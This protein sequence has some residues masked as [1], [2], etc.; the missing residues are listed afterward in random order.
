MGLSAARLRE[1]LLCGF[2]FLSLGLARAGELSVTLLG[3]ATP[4]ASGAEIKIWLNVLNPSATAAAW[5]FPDG[6]NAKLRSGGRELPV[7]LQLAAAAAPDAIAPQG[8]ARAQYTLLLPAG[9]EGDALL[10]AEGLPGRAA[11][12][13]IQAAPAAATAPATS[14]APML[15]AEKAPNWRTQ[16]FDPVNYFKRHLF[17]HEPFYFV[18]GPDSPN[19]KFQ[20][21]FKYQLVDDRSGLAE[22]AGWA[23]NL[24]FGFTQTSL[25]DWNKASAPFEDSSYKPELMFQFQR[26]AQAGDSDWFRLDLQT[27]VMHES[28]GRDG[29]SS[30]SLNLA[31]LRPKLIFGHD[32]GWQFTIA[33]RVWF[34]VGDLV[35]NPDLARYRGHADFRATLS[36]PFDLQLAAFARVGDGFDRGSLQLDLTFPLRQIRWAGFTWYLQAQ[37]FT[38]YGE[39]LLHYNERSEAYRIGFAL[40]R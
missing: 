33:S 9:L 35:D 31:Y 7:R 25:W 34:Y 13:Y 17:P 21:S 6:F 29:D 26:L 2:L 40:Y 16:E 10:E 20:F 30:R 28:N 1:G 32:D 8:F 39:S 5:K 18:V 22:H 36:A 14:S 15:A 37:Y 4:V 3:P 24:F 38:G 27:G 12:L 23:T 11:V 19:A